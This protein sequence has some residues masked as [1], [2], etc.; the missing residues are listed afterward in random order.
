MKAS[1][2]QQ[3]FMAEVQ[4]RELLLFIIAEYAWLS[5]HVFNV[6]RREKDF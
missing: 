2:I 1:N 5:F 3:A 6:A 4:N